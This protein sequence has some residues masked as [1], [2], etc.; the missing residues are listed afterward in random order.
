MIAEIQEVHAPGIRVAVFLDH[1][2]VA[3]RRSRIEADQ[4]GLAGLEEFVVNAHLDPGEIL[5]LLFAQLG[6]GIYTKAAD[7]GADLFESTA[8]EAVAS[9]LMVGTIA[10]ILAALFLNNGDTVGDPCED[11]AGPSL[12]V[13]I[14]ILSTITLVL[15]PLFI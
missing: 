4:D 5:A 12:H 14:E 6:G 13:L 10:G 8:A 2:E 7:V 15:A 11:T 3:I 1:H 9:L